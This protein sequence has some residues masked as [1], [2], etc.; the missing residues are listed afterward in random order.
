MTILSEQEARERLAAHGQDHLLKY[1]PQL[2]E[3]SRKNLLSQVSA[4]DFDLLDRLLEQWV[5]RE[6]EPESFTRIEPVATI[7]PVPS[8]RPDAREALEAGEAALRAGRVGLLLVAGGQGTRLGYEGPKGAY[9]VGPV[10]G[11]SIFAYHAEKIRNL[12][13]RYSC[14]LPWYIMV[15]DTNADA[16]RKF[17]Q[18]NAF[19]GLSE[20]QVYFFQQRMV[21][22]VSETGKIFLDAPDHIAMSPNGHG[23][24][25]P[26]TVENGV[27]ADCH[28]R[29]VDTL[30][31]F[32]VDNW[33]VKVADPY[34]IGYHLLRGGDMSS[35]SH[36]KS[37][38]RE[39]VGVHCICDGEYRVVEYSALDIYP[40][41]LETEQDGSPR[42][43]A[44]N[45][46]IHILGTKFIESIYADYEHFPWWRAHKKI[47]FLNDDGILVKPDAPNGYKFETFVFDALRFIH[48]PPVVLTIDRPGEYTPIKQY[49]GDNSVQS[50]RQAMAD[51]WGAWLEKAGYT[52]PRDE[53]G[54]VTIPIEISPAFALT[55]QE[56]IE[57]AASQNWESIRHLP[58]APIAI[59]EDGSLYRGIST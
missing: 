20:Q 54:A 19:F 22:C 55:E 5:I 28:E 26:A 18:A 40:Q 45:P 2:D 23:G 37:H 8:N 16:T 38:V 49:E 35:K 34:F 9:P 48:H 24:V 41:L 36:S 6:P 13:A 14:Q 29:G 25:I 57:K 10:T 30:S 53:K 51:Y 59:L 17:F 31:Y 50:A 58:D 44:G 42:Y 7:P 47:P 56:F 27:I 43:Y 1:W 11:K 4:I 3:T 12:Q 33:A 21:P 46:A 32:Q 15:S 39:P 52:I